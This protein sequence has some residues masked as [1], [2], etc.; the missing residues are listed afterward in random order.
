MLH[1]KFTFNVLYFDLEFRI[2]L[3]YHV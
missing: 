3:V 1:I 2:I